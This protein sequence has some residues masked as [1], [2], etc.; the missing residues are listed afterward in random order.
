V[1]SALSR[2]LRSLENDASAMQALVDEFR[3]KIITNIM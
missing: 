3:D 1:P 2:S